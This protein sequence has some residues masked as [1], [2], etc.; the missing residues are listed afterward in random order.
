[1]KATLRFL[2]VPLFAL[3]AVAC[4]SPQQVKSD[5]GSS[6]AGVSAAAAAAPAPTTTVPPKAKT[7]ALADLDVVGGS[8]PTSSGTVKINGAVMDDTIYGWA[9]SVPVLNYDLNRGYTTL[10]GH[11]RGGRRLRRHRHR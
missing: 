2:V 7:T 6:G 8:A 1:M 3:V 10:T 4:G 9:C 5:A 11:R